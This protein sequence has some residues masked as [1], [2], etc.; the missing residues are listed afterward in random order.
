MLPLPATQQGEAVTWTRD[1]TALLT[2]SEGRSA[3]VYEVAVPAAATPTPL[4][5][6]SASLP[7]AARTPS[8]TPVRSLWWPAAAAGLTVVVVLCITLSR[9]RRYR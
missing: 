5:S 2:S 6:A 1:G 8:A 9:R 4:A 7:P 3:P